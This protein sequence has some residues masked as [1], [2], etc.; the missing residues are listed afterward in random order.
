MVMKASSPPPPAAAPDPP[1]P[2]SGLTAG[3]GALS[4]IAVIVGGWRGGVYRCL[5]MKL[6]HAVDATWQKAR[7]RVEGEGGEG[8]RARA[9]QDNIKNRNE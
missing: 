9:V 6:S 7:A 5:L 4:A 2:S 1:A 3:G 8:G